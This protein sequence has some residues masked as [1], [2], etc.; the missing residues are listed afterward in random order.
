MIIIIYD[1]NYYDEV[2]RRPR[3]A[4]AARSSA[5]VVV[6]LKN[7]FYCR[8][9]QVMFA[10]RMALFL[11]HLLPGPKML[12]AT[13]LKFDHALDARTDDPFGTQSQ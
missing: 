6:I 5:V 4:R 2:R 10:Y 8:I 9:L 7:I 1:Y 13:K 11:L 3:I 12:S